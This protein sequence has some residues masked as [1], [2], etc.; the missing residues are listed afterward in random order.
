MLEYPGIP[1]GWQNCAQFPPAGGHLST[2]DESRASWPFPLQIFFTDVG[3]VFLNIFIMQLLSDF[4][5]MVK[6]LHRMAK[7]FMVCLEIYHK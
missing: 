2:A 6:I 4:K 3:E 5:F 7:V 1:S